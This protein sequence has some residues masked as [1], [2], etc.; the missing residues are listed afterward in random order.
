MTMNKE[1]FKHK[2]CVRYFETDQMGFVYYSH[3]LVWFEA[4][5]TD[6][7]KKK[8][9]SYKKFE[10]MGYFLPVSEAHCKYISPGHYEDDIIIETW[11]EE[12][13]RASLRIAYR[14]LREK[15]SQLLAKGY[16]IH[17]CINKNRKIVPFPEEFQNIF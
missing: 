3:Y 1:I 5:R 17:P 9:L 15:D 16:T 4:A 12:I 10:E 2:L 6:L 8:G 11:V 13:K 7:L 14:V